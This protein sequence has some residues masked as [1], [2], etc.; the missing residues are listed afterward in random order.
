MSFLINPY[1]F[2]ATGIANTYSMNFDWTTTVASIETL[3]IANQ[4]NAI[5]TALRDTT[6]NFSISLWFKLTAA[7]AGQKR[8]LFAKYDNYSGWDRCFE[9]TIDA[10]NKLNVYGQY[11]TTN[12]TVQLQTTATYSDTNG[13]V[14]VVF[15]YDCTQSTAGT[16]AKLYVN[17][18]E[19][20]SYSIQTVNTTQK[21]FYNQTNSARRAYV[22]TTDYAG[23]SANLASRGAD[24]KIDE[25]TFWDKSLSAA[26]VTQ[27]YNSGDAYDVSLMSSYSSNCL[28][29]YRMGDN[30]GDVWGGSSWT[31][32]NVKGTA[33]TDLVSVNM[34]EAD[35]VTDVP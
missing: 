10:S 15:V 20:T 28:A 33:S 11:D 16:I 17:G 3:R 1:V 31:I 30:A 18:T 23:A 35:R 21:Y 27:L 25:L 13:W 24:G 6:P 14:H 19:V 4:S 22:G 8:I 29:W 7:N 5:D 12:S 32:V 9:M 2:A 26:E 34:E